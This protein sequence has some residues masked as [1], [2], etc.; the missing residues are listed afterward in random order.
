MYVLRIYENIYLIILI[1]FVMEKSKSYGHLSKIAFRGPLLEYI[2][3]G[4]HSNQVVV[5]CLVLRHS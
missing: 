3:P 4:A 2:L 1:R 5:K